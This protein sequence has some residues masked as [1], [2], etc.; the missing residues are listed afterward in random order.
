MENFV[1]NYNWLLTAIAAL[2]GW[3]LVNWI[4]N[5]KEIK[6]KALAEAVS[7]E[8]D[9]LVKRYSVMEEEINQLKRQVEELQRQVIELQEDRINLI[10]RNKE[11]ELQL[12]EAQSHICM[13]PD[14]EC[15]K[16]LPSR[17]YCRLKRLSQGY[18]DKYYDKDKTE[19]KNA[20]ISKEPD[21][22]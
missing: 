16:R 18:Y 15:L 17:T 22:K 2:G 9:S 7:L 8:T 19:N 20:E 5:R 12:K 1:S 21:K 4:L 14:D 13:V 10:V 11:L 6:K 3:K